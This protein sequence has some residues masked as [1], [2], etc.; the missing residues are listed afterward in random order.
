MGEKNTRKKHNYPPRTQAKN[1][2]GRSTQGGTHP[3]GEGA[4]FGGGDE[5]G[6]GI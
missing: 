5:G 6:K 1:G 3:E 2:F 4:L